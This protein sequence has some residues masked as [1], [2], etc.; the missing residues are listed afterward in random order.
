MTVYIEYVLIDN[1]IIDYLLLNVAHKL[2][3]QKSGRIR[4]GVCA[5][6][7]AVGALIYPILERWFILSLAFKLVLG[8]LI[9]LLSVKRITVREFYLSF[10]AFIFLTFLVGGAITGIFN[11][12]K[13]DNSSEV[14]VAVIIVPAYIVLRAC[15]AVIRYFY[16]KKRVVC[17]TTQVELILGG[18]T[19][20][21]TGFLDTGNAL[22]D[23]DNPVIVCEKRVIEKFIERVP[24]KV[25]LRKL[26]VGTISDVEQNFCLTL[27]YVKI[28]NGEKPN[29]YNNVTACLSKLSV[30]DGYGVILHPALM[31]ECYVERGQAEIK[32]VS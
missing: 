7:G 28:Y 24:Q 11:L 15:T 2:T 30:G 23:G 12:F 16:R 31:E 25:K 21:E 8:A 13:I 29:I 22:Y 14:V 26:T 10:L 1:F 19:V 18:V 20:K 3:G 5:L 32:K 6:I 4:K 9:V 17:L 27:D